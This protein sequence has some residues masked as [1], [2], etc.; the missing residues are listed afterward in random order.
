MLMVLLA[1]KGHALPTSRQFYDDLFRNGT[2]AGMR[3]FEQDFM[4]A[5]N[6]DTNLTN[7]DLNVGN[8]WL[9]AMDAAAGDANITL[10]F[11]MMNGVH[12]LVSVES[13]EYGAVIESM[14]QLQKRS[15]C[16]Y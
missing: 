15:W 1:F 11:C 10:Q 12:A 6:T 5:I 7:S 4:C 16:S 8:S 13:L 9:A 3:M 14:V 2:R